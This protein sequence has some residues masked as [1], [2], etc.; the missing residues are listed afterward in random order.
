MTNH[1]SDEANRTFVLNRYCKKLIAYGHSPQKALEIA[2]DA[3]RGDKFAKDYVWT[4]HTIVG[5]I[6]P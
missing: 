1:T 2:F 6:A 5:E 4:I 3:V